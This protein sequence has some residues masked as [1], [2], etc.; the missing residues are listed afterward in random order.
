MIALSSVVVI[1][2]GIVGIFYY[3]RRKA[4]KLNT[5]LFILHLVNGTQ[6]CPVKV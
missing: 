4:I 6:Y 1:G 5:V 2:G 3:K